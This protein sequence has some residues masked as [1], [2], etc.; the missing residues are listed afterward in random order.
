[1]SGVSDSGGHRPNLLVEPGRPAVQRGRASVDPSV[2]AAACRREAETDLPDASERECFRN[3][4]DEEASAT[5]EQI[6]DC[7]LEAIDRFVSCYESISCTDSL[8]LEACQAT[9]ESE[10]SRC[11][12]VSARLQEALSLCDEDDGA[13]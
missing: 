12:T 4:F 11:G 7:Q 13:P 2:D 5:D 3:T 6:I 1:M 9:F 8:A 10:G